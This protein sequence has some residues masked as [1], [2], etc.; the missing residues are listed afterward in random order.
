M[1]TDKKIKEYVDEWC[2][3]STT[4]YIKEHLVNLLTDFRNDI[5]IVID[6]QL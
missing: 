5:K 2:E 4:N 1:I 3:R 6:E